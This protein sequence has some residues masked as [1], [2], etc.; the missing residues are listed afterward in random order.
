LGVYFRFSDI[1]D[2]GFGIRVNDEEERIEF[3][4]E[5]EDGY[6]SIPEADVVYGKIRKLLKKQIEGDK[7]L[8]ENKNFRKI[9]DKLA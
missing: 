9:L 4:Q 1:E 3:L 2:A 6:Y 8:L 7:T 5:G